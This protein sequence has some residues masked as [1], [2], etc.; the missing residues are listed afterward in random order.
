MFALVSGETFETY[1]GQQKQ[2]EFT[3]EEIILISL[4]TFSIACFKSLN[5]D[6]DSEKSP[7]LSAIQYV[8][9][10]QQNF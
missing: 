10:P 6:P 8:H 1:R 7:V 2:I 5:L 4:K 3:R 9:D